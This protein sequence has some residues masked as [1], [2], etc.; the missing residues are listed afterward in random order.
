[1]PDGLDINLTE[2]MEREGITEIARSRSWA[3]ERRFHVRIEGS[4]F[5][6]VGA[7]VAD[8]LADARAKT[9]RWKND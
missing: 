7:T 9:G 4:G 2:I 3:P 6:G 5:T 1:M 8:A